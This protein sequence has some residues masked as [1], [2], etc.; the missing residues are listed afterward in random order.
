LQFAKIWGP[1]TYDG[2][3][4]KNSYVLADRDVIEFHI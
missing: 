1:H 3:R 4:V 2:Q